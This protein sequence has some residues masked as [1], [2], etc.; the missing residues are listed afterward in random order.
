MAKKLK[1]TMISTLFPLLLKCC[2]HDRP[3][4]RSI[5]VWTLTKYTRLI[6]WTAKNL[7]NG[8]GPTVIFEPTLLVL[9]ELMQDQVKKVCSFFYFFFSPSHTYDI[10]I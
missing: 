5:S 6:C 9:L 2:K 3:L 10:Y 4:I 8:G 1:N 7:Q